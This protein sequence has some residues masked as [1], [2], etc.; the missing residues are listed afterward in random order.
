MRKVSI[1]VNPESQE[2]QERMPRGVV[3]ASIEPAGRYGV[4]EIIEQMRAKYGY[5]PLRG[6]IPTRV[7]REIESLYGETCFLIPA[8]MTPDRKPRYPICDAEGNI[9]CELLYRAYIRAKG[10]ETR[11]KRGDVYIFYDPEFVWRKA[12]DI[13]KKVGC[14]WALQENPDAIVK[15]EIIPT[16]DV[17]GILAIP[18]KIESDI[19]LHLLASG[20]QTELIRKEPVNTISIMYTIDFKSTADKFSEIIE[21]TL[22]KYNIEFT[23]SET[24]KDNKMYI[25]YQFP[26]C[27]K[28]KVYEAFIEIINT[29]KDYIVSEFKLSHDVFIH[30]FA[31]ELKFVWA[32]LGLKKEFEQTESNPNFDFL[33]KIY[34]VSSPLQRLFMFLTDATIRGTIQTISPQ[35]FVKMSNSPYDLLKFFEKENYFNGL[36]FFLNIVP[37]LKEVEI[38]PQRFLESE[39]RKRL[40]KEI[41]KR[42]NV[43]QRLYIFLLVYFFKYHSKD[44]EIQPNIEK[45]INELTKDDLFKLEYLLPDVFIDGIRFLYSLLPLESLLNPIENPDIEVEG[46]AGEYVVAGMDIETEPVKSNEPEEISIRDLIRYKRL[47]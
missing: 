41:Y 11:A 6:Q 3:K 18:T 39:E 12:L 16:I 25:T 5:P 44:E 7:R 35:E 28:C 26:K 29:I 9:R 23:K 47:E 45:V 43:A 17:D 30:S 21:N 38:K 37:F 36:K 4:Y 33:R 31:P 40:Y 42:L 24:Q 13:A 15:E 19:E 32:S 14:P 27:R 1:V 20:E 22:R 34:D 8:F 2:N 10:V 46:L